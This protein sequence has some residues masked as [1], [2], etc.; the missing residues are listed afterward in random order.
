MPAIAS[1][2]L[3]NELQ[4]L[5][6]FK[7]HIPVLNGHMTNQTDFCNQPRGEP[8]VQVLQRRLVRSQQTQQ[9]NVPFLAFFV[10]PDQRLC[11]LVI[12]VHER[13]GGNVVGVLHLSL[14]RVGR[15]HVFEKGG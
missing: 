9:I 7:F 14:I 3:Q 10:V 2:Q 6:L 5:F 13:V 1:Q 12:P 8:D 11:S 15:Q 4:V